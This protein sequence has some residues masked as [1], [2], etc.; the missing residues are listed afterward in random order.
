M[1]ADGLAKIFQPFFTTKETGMGMG[2][3]IAQAIIQAH[4]GRIWG[5]NQDGGGAVFRISLPVASA[6]KKNN[7]PRDRAAFQ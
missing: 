5:E 7:Q 6:K 1:T 3:S 4:G 2:L